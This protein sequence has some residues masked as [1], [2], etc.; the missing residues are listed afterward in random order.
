LGERQFQDAVAYD[1]NRVI[2]GKNTIGIVCHEILKEL[3]S[4]IV[5]IHIDCYSAGFGYNRT[6]V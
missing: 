6:P 1:S 3:V 4:A 2:P 5:N